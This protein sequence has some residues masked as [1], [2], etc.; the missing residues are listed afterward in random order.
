MSEIKAVNLRKL[1]NLPQNV[2]V[3]T[4]TS[5]L[6][7][8]ASEMVLNLLPLFLANVIGVRTS[9]IGFIEG[10]A[11]SSASLLKII[12]GWFSDRIGKRKWLTVAGYFLSTIVKPFL[13]FATSWFAVLGVRF[14]DRVGKG[15]RNAPRDALI[16]D[17]AGEDQR[18]LAFGVHRAGDT[19][20]ATIGLII[21]FLFVWA[22]QAGRLALERETFQRVVLF[23]IIPGGLAVLVLALGARDTPI[24][25]GKTLPRLSLREFDGRFRRFI[26]VLV[27]FTLGNSAD[28]FLILRAQAQGMSV[29]AILGMLITFNLVYAILSGPLGSL[30]DKIG[31]RRLILGGWLAYTIL[32]T[33]FALSQTTWQLWLLYS[34]YGIYYGAFEG[35][36]KAYVADIV[37]SEKRGTAYG[38]YNAALGV[39]LFPASLIAGVLWQGI[40]GWSGFGPSAPFLFGAAL[41]LIA[42]GLFLLWVPAS[43]QTISS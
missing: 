34:L 9:T 18:G 30:S 41:A 27:I 23:S 31:R 12:S 3:L 39:A 17:S 22:T 37:P 26:Y 8:I 19:A 35:V 33:G 7:D 1:R 29:L 28:A 40:G 21:A 4:I 32:Y 20:G 24:A 5:L 6:N 10:I 25:D 42:S 43:N 38:L 16:A 11:E 14:T 15:I 36:A 13:Y 2:W